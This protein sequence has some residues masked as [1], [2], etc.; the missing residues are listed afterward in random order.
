MKVLAI[1]NSFSQD[2][3]RYLHSIASNEGK[4]MKVVN[5]YIGGCSLERHYNNMLSGE[6][7]YSMELCGMSSG[8]Y[9]SLK[10]ALLSDSWDFITIQQSSPKSVKMETYSPYAQRLCDFIRLHAPKAKLLIHQTW[11]Y[12]EGSQRLTEEMGYSHFVD[13][14]KDAHDCYEQLAKDVDAYGIIPSGDVFV[15]MYNSGIRD[16][17]RDTFHASFGVG[18]YALALTW[19][20]YLYGER[21]QCPPIKL[22]KPVE[23]EELRLVTSCVERVVFGNLSEN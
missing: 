6:D 19:F 18:R 7:A 21:P 8:F 14:C 11:G 17:H 12:E 16:I 4:R 15:E 10:E 1:G 9:V 2:A 22:D 23:E 13:M 3:T 5:L 20:C